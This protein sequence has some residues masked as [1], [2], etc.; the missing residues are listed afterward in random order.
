ML[1]EKILLSFIALQHLGFLILEM[2]FWTQP[3]GRKVF[4]M[5]AEQ[6]QSTAVLAANQGLYNGFLAAGLTWAVICSDPA[7]ANQLGIFFASC[8]LVA[9]IYGA[10][11][12]N[13]R[14]FLIQGMPALVYLVLSLINKVM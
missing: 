13:K 6:A 1:M 2:F 4:R 11:S 10:Y 9:G 14:I 5:S 12:V 8:V 7:M 3:L